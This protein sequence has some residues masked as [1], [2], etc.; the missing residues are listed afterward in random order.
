MFVRPIAR[1]AGL[2][3]API[4]VLAA[5]LPAAASSVCL[6]RTLRPDCC[7]TPSADSHTRI[8]RRC[9]CEIDEQSTPSVPQAAQTAT[10]PRGSETAVHAPPPIAVTLFA[11]D[12][13]AP[14]RAPLVP[15]TTGPPILLVTRSF[16]L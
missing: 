12:A 6:G 4:L 9:C 16:R 3:L 8:E 5:A 11:P 14:T 7:C 15:P 13:P 2:A 10:S 1:F